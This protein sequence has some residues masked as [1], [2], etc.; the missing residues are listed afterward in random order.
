MA[1]PRPGQPVRGSQSGAPIM[2]IFDLLGRRWA[3]GI[4]WNLSQG[5]ATFRSLQASC[6]TISPS[7]LNRRLK[8]LKEAELIDRSL[9]GYHLTEMGEE[10]FGLLKPFGVWSLTW[11]Q[12]VSPEQK[13][14]WDEIRKKASD[15]SGC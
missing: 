10:L 12:T 15:N 1:I 3:M 11:A 5:A 9:D 6:E 7:I 4:I 13:E 8:E 14:C 2:A